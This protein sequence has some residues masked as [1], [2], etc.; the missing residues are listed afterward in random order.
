M[1]GITAPQPKTFAPSR[2]DVLTTLA[3]FFGSPV[4]PEKLKDYSEH[5]AQVKLVRTR[6]VRVRPAYTP[7]H[8]PF[9]CRQTYHFPGENLQ[10]QTVPSTQIDEVPRTK[11]AQL[12][13]QHKERRPSRVARGSD[14]SLLR[15]RLRRP[16]HQAARHHEQPHPQVP[17]E[18]ADLHLPPVRA[19]HRHGKLSQ[20]PLLQFP[21]EPLRRSCAL[22]VVEWDE[23]HFDVRLL[24]RVPV[25]CSYSNCAGPTEHRMELQTV[26]VVSPG[27]LS[28]TR[29]LLGSTKASRACKR[30]CAGTP[31]R[32]HVVVAPHHMADQ[33]AEHDNLEDC[34]GH[35]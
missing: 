8:L 19:D 10:T 11:Q 29:R 5:H 12:W 9:S 26:T 34:P 30:A 16:Q 20:R 22:Q 2:E 31:V 33:H 35:E 6:V 3:Y 28:R 25:S 4:S 24:Q 1:S 32:Q 13:R 23:I 17:P 7:V 21:V 27:G 14:S 18:L 15:R